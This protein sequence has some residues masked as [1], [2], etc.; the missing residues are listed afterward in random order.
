MS[1]AH[2]PRIYRE[3]LGSMTNS[4]NFA[5]SGSVI[6]PRRRF[7][8]FGAVLDS[9]PVTVKRIPTERLTVKKGRGSEQ[10]LSSLDTIYG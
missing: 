3:F 4:G 8:G 6:S 10:L 5:L 7:S 1:A 9:P 2:F